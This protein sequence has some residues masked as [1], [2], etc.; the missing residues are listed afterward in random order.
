RL[1]R[2]H[3]PLLPP[4]PQTLGPQDAL[5]AQT[6]ALLGR[7][8]DPAAQS[9]YDLRLDP[10]HPQAYALIGEAAAAAGEACRSAAHQLLTAEEPVVLYL[11]DGDR[12]LTHLQGDPRVGAW[13][14]ED[15]MAEASYLLDRLCDE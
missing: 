5:T 4:L 1:R 10:Q 9:Q 12:S 11:L 13:L 7:V 3:T 15:H 2:A 6:G 14:S 8:D